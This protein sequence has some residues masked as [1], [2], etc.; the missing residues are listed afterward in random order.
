MCCRCRALGV[1]CAATQE[2]IAARYRGDAGIERDHDVI[3]TEMFERNSVA[4][5]ASG[6]A[7]TQNTAGMSL[8]SDVP[9]AAAERGP[10]L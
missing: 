4:E 9:P 8:T 6:W 5:I 10:C 1:T 2:G 7:N 3:R